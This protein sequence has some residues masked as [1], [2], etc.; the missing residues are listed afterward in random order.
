MNLAM[1]SCFA[2]GPYKARYLHGWTNAIFFESPKLCQQLVKILKI[3]RFY[4]KMTLKNNRPNPKAAL[5]RGLGLSSK[6]NNL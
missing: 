1:S 5:E 4:L 2:A 3:T 6:Q